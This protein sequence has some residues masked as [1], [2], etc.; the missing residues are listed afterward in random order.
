MCTHVAMRGWT[1]RFAVTELKHATYIY[2]LQK[3]L[4]DWKFWLQKGELLKEG[5]CVGRAAFSWKKNTHDNNKKLQLEMEGT[6]NPD[7]PWSIHAPA[8]QDLEVLG[9]YCQSVC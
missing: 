4:F 2:R 1:G 3:S 5:V 6:R 9:R 7:A 8:T